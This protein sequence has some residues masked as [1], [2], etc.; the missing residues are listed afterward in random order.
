MDDT[1]HVANKKN[2]K[3]I[4]SKKLQWKQKKFDLNDT[5]GTYLDTISINLIYNPHKFAQGSSHRYNWLKCKEWQDT[6]SS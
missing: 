5:Y 4:S 2:K 6:L 1:T 3:Y